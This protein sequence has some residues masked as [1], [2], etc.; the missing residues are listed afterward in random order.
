MIL[1]DRQRTCRSVHLA[2]AGEHHGRRMRQ[3]SQRLEEP[4]PQHEV[5]VEIAPGFVVDVTATFERKREM[6][7]MHASQREWLR[8]HHGTDDYLADM[9]RWTRTRGELAG[10]KYGEGFRQYLGHP[11]P[12]TP[13]LQELLGQECVILTE[14]G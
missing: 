7:A 1:L 6:L 11:Y 4:D 10:C 13:L 2:S 5:T 14:L 12:R 9:E 8:Q 3:P